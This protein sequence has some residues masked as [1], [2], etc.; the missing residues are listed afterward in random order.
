MKKISNMF[1]IALLGAI[2]SN[3]SANE[4]NTLQNISYNEKDGNFRI[5]LDFA[6]PQ[7]SKNF[8]LNPQGKDLLI[9]FDNVSY[10]MFNDNF[11]T[12]SNIVKNIKLAEKNDNLQMIVSMNEMQPYNIKRDGN[13]IELLISPENKIKSNKSVDSIIKESVSDNIIDSIDF[14]RVDPHQ[15]KVLIAYTAKTA[16][17][18]SIEN[19]DHLELSFPKAKLI[20][21]LFRKLDVK[22][23]GTPIDYIV[24]KV[25][26]DKNIVVV[27]IYFKDKTK[28]KSVIQQGQRKIEIL[29]QDEEAVKKN[30]VVKFQGENISFNFQDIPVR[31]VLQMIAQKMKV[32]LVIGDNVQ[33]NITLQLDNVPYDQ[34]L[35][36]ILKT[37]DLDKRVTGNVM[38]ISTFQDLLERETKELKSKEDLK[39]LAPIEQAT[40]QVKYAKAKILTE[41]IQKFSTTRGSIVFDERTNKVIISDTKDRIEDLKKKIESLDIPVRQ[42]VIEARIVFAKTNAQRE[43]G[44]QWGA[45]LNKS[46]NSGKGNVIGGGTSEGLNTI[47]DNINGGVV[48]RV[49]TSSIVNMAVPNATSGIALGFLSDTFSLDVALSALEKTGDVEIVARPKVI[50]A[51]QKTATIE[52]G[53]EYP[54][55][56]LS[57]NGNSGVSFKK[58]LLSL[59]VTPQITPNDKIMLDLK[60]IQDSVAELTN[61]GPAIDSTKIDTQVLSNN[62][63]TIVLGGIFKSDSVN[64]DNKTPFL[65][66]IPVVGNLFKHTS[67]SNERSELIIFITPKIVESEILPSE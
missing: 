36:I 48:G 29:V 63:E 24:S 43:L 17:Y 26:N 31:N 66:S 42:V 51:D 37:K 16:L 50:T 23:F 44:V 5:V 21:T 57:D 38:I 18:E 60:I 45:G 47:T 12:D 2:I 49:P 62:G 30:Q 1:K 6:N 34:A 65:S 33:G 11:T 61:S 56:E 25:D 19:S 7:D 13:K 14:E 41:V 40:I 28:T 59:G 9:N 58:I 3:A 39:T 55:M 46:V 4:I 10:N 64:E 35:D 67:K 53:K 54:Y 27:K 22:D 15:A 52:S 20:S 8:H 32:N